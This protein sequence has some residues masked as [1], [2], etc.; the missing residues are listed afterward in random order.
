MSIKIYDQCGNPITKDGKQAMV[1][2]SG[3]RGLVASDDYLN[4]VKFLED[5]HAVIKSFESMDEATRDAAFK[6]ALV[7]S[8][9]SLRTIEEDDGSFNLRLEM[10]PQPRKQ[11]AMVAV[12]TKEQTE[13]F[14]VKSIENLIPNLPV[15]LGMDLLEDME[16]LLHYSE[17]SDIH[18]DNLIEFAAHL[19]T[20]VPSTT[21]EE[22]D[23][24]N[25]QIAFDNYVA[26]IGPIP[27]SEF[28]GSVELHFNYGLN[29]QPL[30]D[31]EITSDDIIPE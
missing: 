20:L 17:G 5:A 8:N 29:N 27:I 31:F 14:F 23:L 12:L 25:A 1:H 3:I 30:E 13:R 26:S 24:E 10:A 9:A 21:E 7:L 15:D 4:S 11:L 22:E 16:E 19:T 18:V 28:G 2:V 6:M